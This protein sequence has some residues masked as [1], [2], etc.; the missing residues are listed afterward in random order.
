MPKIYITLLC[1]NQ[2]Q[3]M[4][5]AFQ[6]VLGKTYTCWVCIVMEVLML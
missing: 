5:K 1:Y 4:E 6:L 2:V 3:F